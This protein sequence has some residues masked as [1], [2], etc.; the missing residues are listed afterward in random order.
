MK[1]YEVSSLMQRSMSD[2]MKLRSMLRHNAS[3]MPKPCSECRVR[4]YDLTV[5]HLDLL[6]A[7]VIVKVGGSAESLPASEQA[8]L[9]EVC[10]IHG[11]V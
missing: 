4:Y 1:V 7:Q 3:I 6:C 2:G 8:D 10:R 11:S 5:S 9:I